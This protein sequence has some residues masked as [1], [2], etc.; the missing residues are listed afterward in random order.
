MIYDRSCRGRRGLPGLSHAWW[1]GAQL[2]RGLRRLDAYRGVDSWE[3]ALEFL[4]D[5]RS[6]HP[7][8]EVQ[9]WGHGKWGGARVR[10]QLLDRAALDRRHPLHARLAAVRDRMQP[11]GQ[12]LWWFRTCETLGARPGQRFATELAEFLD[13]RIAGH[14]YIIGH[15]QSG[16]HTLAPGERPTW[17]E[18]EG[19]LEGSPEEPRRAHWS[20]MRAP[21]TITCLRGTIPAGY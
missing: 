9:Y 16:L 18:D 3:E 11:G 17:P 8:A 6:D 21:N 12:A 5:F 1:A 2:Y 19:L 15:V 7:L 14:T 10:Q 4:A 20:R 13:A